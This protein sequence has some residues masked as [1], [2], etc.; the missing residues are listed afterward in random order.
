MVKKYME[1]GLRIIETGF[2]GLKLIE[3][4]V[5]RDARGFFMESWSVKA[6]RE[7]GVACGF[8]QDNHARSETK[9]VLRGLHFQTP[10]CAQAKLVRVTLGAVFDVAVDIRLGSPTYGKSYSVI[11]SDENFLQLFIPKGFA[12]GYATLTEQTEFQYKVD[13]PYAPECDAGIIWNDPSAAIPWPVREP[14]LSGKDALLPR[15][16][17]F[18][19][20]FVFDPAAPA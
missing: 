20:P 17:E 15:L 6:F 3:P 10:P 18:T 1:N 5:F 16:A 7:A 14:M 2:P 13:A 8:V 4:K 11:L 19:S 12:H 9:G